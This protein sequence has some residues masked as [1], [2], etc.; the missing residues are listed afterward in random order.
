MAKQ[1][2]ALRQWAK[3]TVGEITRGREK[4]EED[5]GIIILRGP[6]ATLFLAI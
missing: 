6:V 4:R 1:I 5:C 2:T 3:G